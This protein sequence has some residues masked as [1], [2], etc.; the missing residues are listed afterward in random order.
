[1]YLIT[2]FDKFMIFYLGKIEGFFAV[3]NITSRI[4]NA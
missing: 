3:E 2:D 1:M 4:H